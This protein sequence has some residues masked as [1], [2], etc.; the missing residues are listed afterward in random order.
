MFTLAGSGPPTLTGQCSRTKGIDP[1][2]VLSSSAM[3]GKHESAFRF[4]LAPFT[5][6]SGVYRSLGSVHPTSPSTPEL[7]NSLPVS[8]APLTAG[9][10]HCLTNGEPVVMPLSSCRGELI[11]HIHQCRLLRMKRNFTHVH[12]TPSAL[13][14]G[15]FRIRGDSASTFSVASWVGQTTPSPMP[16]WCSIFICGSRGRLENRT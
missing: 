2:V 14:A 8:P 1:I 12:P 5:P 11:N 13:D 6:S 9:D 10:P 3:F 15:K 4:I 7:G 16:R